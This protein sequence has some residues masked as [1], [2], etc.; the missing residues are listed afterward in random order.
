MQCPKCQAEN[1]EGL[2]FCVACGKKLETICPKCGF[3]NSPTFKFCGECGQA[4][5]GP[6][7]SAPLKS[8]PEKRAAPSPLPGELKEKILAQKD[9]IEG[10]RRQVTV[11]FCDLEGYTPLTEKLGPEE[12][13]A[14]MDRDLRKSSSTRSTTLKGPSTR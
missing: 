2:K 3:A 1:P 7:E 14:L 13:Y 9:R 11:L 8:F 12:A 6:S 4:L 5:S 10:E